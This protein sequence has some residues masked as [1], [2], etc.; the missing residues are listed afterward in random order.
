MAHDP[1][2]RKDSQI[3]LFCFGAMGWETRAGNVDGSPRSCAASA[4]DWSTSHAAGSGPPPDAT[5]HPIFASVASQRT[6]VTWRRLMSWVAAYESFK[7][8]MR[9]S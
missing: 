9:T 8:A 6:D 7:S 5:A 1:L 4:G 3:L 2:L